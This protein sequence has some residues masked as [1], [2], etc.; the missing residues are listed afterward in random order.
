MKLSWIDREEIVKD[1]NVSKPNHDPCTP[2]REDP[3]SFFGISLDDARETAGEDG[4]VERGGTLFPGR[5]LEQIVRYAEG[6][7]EFVVIELVEDDGED[8]GR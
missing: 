4:T 5:S 7:C 1:V 8:L 6:L 3:M 2:L